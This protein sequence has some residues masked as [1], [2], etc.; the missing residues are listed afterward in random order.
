MIG[1]WFNVLKLQ[2]KQNAIFLVQWG[3]NNIVQLRVCLESEIASFTKLIDLF[4]FSLLL[5]M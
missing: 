3:K 1:L 4:I 2:G 5:D